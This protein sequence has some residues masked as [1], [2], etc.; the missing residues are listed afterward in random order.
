MRGDKG[1]KG[2]LSLP[3]NDHW[4][5]QVG[6]L[7]GLPDGAGRHAA[8]RLRELGC[9]VGGMYGTF[10]W[11]TAGADL[12]ESFLGVARDLVRGLAADLCRDIRIGRH[13]NPRD[14]FDSDTG[15]AASD[16]YG[17]I[18]IA[19]IDMGGSRRRRSAASFLTKPAGRD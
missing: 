19:R 3:L 11:R 6:P 13:A 16:R 2:V 8:R 5:V 7:A 18:W 15:P 12:T 10:E 9:G 14:R 4:Y 1:P 17:D